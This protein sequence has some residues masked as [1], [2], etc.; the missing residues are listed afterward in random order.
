LMVELPNGDFAFTIVRQFLFSACALVHADALKRSAHSDLAG[1]AEKIHKESRYHVR[2]AGDWMLK[3]GDG[4]D[5]SHE[6][7]QS[8]LNELWRYTG[9]LF[10]TD[11]LERRLVASKVAVESAA[12]KPAWDAQVGDVLKRAGLTT[13]EVKWMQ[14][15]GR[16]GKH[17]EHLGHMLAEMQILA[18]SFPGV[19]W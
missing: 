1:I 3:L 17:T 5:E 15:G 18:R 4:T 10:V 13:P 14:A 19:E 8:A 16:A 11:D 9:E 7:A 12:L 6:R 2:H